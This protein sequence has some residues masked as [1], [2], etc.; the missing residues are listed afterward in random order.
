[1]SK[2]LPKRKYSDQDIL[3]LAN[4]VFHPTMRDHWKAFY[5]MYRAI[6]KADEWPYR[7]LEDA[8]RMCLPQPY[9]LW[10]RIMRRMDDVTDDRYT[11]PM[12]LRLMVWKTL[13]N[14]MLKRRKQ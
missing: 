1:M 8:V 11:T 5:S 9:R 3:R 2:T 6:R 14:V 4:W 7:Q 13:G 12:F 10:F